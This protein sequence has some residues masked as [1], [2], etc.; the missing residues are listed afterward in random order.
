MQIKKIE[1][2]HF[3]KL[4][5]YSLDF[6]DGLNFIYGRNEDGKSTIMAFIRMMFYG[7][8]ANTRDIST[9]TRKRYKPWNGSAMGGAIEF[10]AEGVNYRLQKRFGVSAGKDEVELIN[11]DTGFVEELDH[12]EEVGSHFF[13]MELD[14]F[15]RS[16]FIGRS[17]GFGS[18]E[19]DGITERLINLTTS[20]DEKLSVKNATNNLNAAMEKLISKRGNAGLLV[21]ARERVSELDR[22]LRNANALEASQRTLRDRYDT[23]L[24]V[25]AAEKE[26]LEGVKLK[27]EAAG[28]ATDEAAGKK[29]EYQTAERRAELFEIEKEKRAELANLKLLQAEDSLKQASLAAEEKERLTLLP[30]FAIVGGVILLVAL[31]LALFVSTWLGL[32]GLLSIILFVAE[33]S[34]GR[35]KKSMAGY[36]KAAAERAT[37]LE[38][39]LELLLEKTGQEDEEDEKHL[40]TLKNE[41]ENAK[42]A[43]AHAESKVKELRSQLLAD[44]DLEQEIIDREGEIAGIRGQLQSPK[45]PI[46][47]ILEEKEEAEEKLAEYETEYS[48]LKLALEVMESAAEELRKNFGPRLSERT[49]EI[50]SG[51]T[52]GRYSN[53]TVTRDYGIKA[54]QEGD[55]FYHEGGYLSN[56]TVDQVYFALRLAIVELLTENTEQLP[57]FLDDIFEQYDDARTEDGLVFLK[58]Y[59][60]E[61][62]GQ[63]LLFSCH[64]HIIDKART[65]APLAHFH[66]L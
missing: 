29:E 51:L 26:R 63:V 36:R 61:Q 50:F 24:K 31:L 7:S 38:D 1:I 44:D 53:V 43:Y 6:S 23:L 18:S 19:N 11:M 12:H 8:Q 3:G 42:K 58:T 9:N 40:Q 65:I 66:T 41:A 39:E 27:R 30:V 52:G 48:A 20:A 21:A 13:K 46:S 14:G 2:E 25:Q 15:E 37:T 47:L 5:N 62:G 33:F 16:M 64:R 10:E 57:L 59:A 28:I 32:L 60:Q 54:L 49:A 22:A 34:A 4:N 35:R 17:G 56:G 55:I 45:K